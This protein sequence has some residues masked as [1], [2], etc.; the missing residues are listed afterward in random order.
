[1][2]RNMKKR[3]KNLFSKLKVVALIPARGG[4]KG[5]KSKNLYLIGS[6]PLIAWSIEAA[7]K[8]KIVDKIFVSTQDKN[9]A[10]YAKHFG[11]EIH[12]R[13]K[14]YSGDNSLVHKAIESFLE[15]LKLELKYVPDILVLLEPTTPF[16]EN[17]LITKCLKKMLSTGSDS[18]A[19]F[20]PTKTK[21]ERCWNLDKNGKPES[22]SKDPWKLRQKLKS[23]YELDGALY[24]FKVNE[25]NK[26]SKG[27]L[28]GK[29]TSFIRSNANNI[30]LDNP[31][32]IKYANTIIED[33]YEK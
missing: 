3:K 33:L 19:T 16:R 17:N 10:F 27:L 7:K 2:Q 13:N 6:K 30:E 32:D 25:K 29:P 15:Y 23:S 24:A 12:I 21:P 9:I 18:I 22:Y 28:F 8:E 14:K 31:T 4:S 20:I 11:A 26:L 5:I 1:M